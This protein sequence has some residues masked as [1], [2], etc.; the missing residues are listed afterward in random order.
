[1]FRIVYAQQQPHPSQDLIHLFG[2]SPLAATVARTDPI[3]GEKLNKLRKSYEGQVKTFGLAG[4]NKAV[5]T[6]SGV[7]GSLVNLMAWPE[8]E[9]QN[10]V[11]A[12][13]G[14]EKGLSAATLAKLDKAV[15]LEPGPVP[16]NDEWENILGLEKLKAPLPIVEMKGK[17]APHTASKLP[18]VN[19]HVN[20]MIVGIPAGEVERPKRTGRKRRYDERSFEGYGEGFVDDDGMDV[21]GYSSGEGSRKSSVSKKKRKKVFLVHATSRCCVCA[22]VDANRSMLPLTLLGHLSVVAVMVR[23]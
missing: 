19:G 7:T 20:G 15:R 6:E 11:V 18:K 10:Q 13:K 17:P 4:R 8:D 12:G 16:K 3:T 5:K 1:M 23:A 2:L 21:G 14:L 22:N 9:W